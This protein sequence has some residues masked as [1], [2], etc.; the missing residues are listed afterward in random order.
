VLQPSVLPR[1]LSE[2]SPLTIT[3]IHNNITVIALSLGNGD[4]YEKVFTCSSPKDLSNNLPKYCTKAINRHVH[5]YNV[6]GGESTELLYDVVL[7]GCKIL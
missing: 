7:L 2:E 5:R 4:K 6:L 3:I 1:N